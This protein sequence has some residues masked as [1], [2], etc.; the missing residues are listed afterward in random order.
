[1]VHGV[2]PHQIDLNVRYQTKGISNRTG[3]NWEM[4][5]ISIQLFFELCPPNTIFHL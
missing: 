4:E 3:E 2:E 5:A 1:M